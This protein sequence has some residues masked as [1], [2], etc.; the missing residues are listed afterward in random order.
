MRRCQLIDDRTRR[1]IESEALRHRALAKIVQEPLLRQD[2]LAV[3]EALE[4]F[5]EVNYEEKAICETAH[6]GRV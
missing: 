4:E 2:H 1:L 6:G 3:A 5:L